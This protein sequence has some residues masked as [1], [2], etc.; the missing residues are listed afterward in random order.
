MRPI[1]HF[2]TRYPE[3]FPFVFIFVHERPHIVG[4][5]CRAECESAGEIGFV[6]V[7]EPSLAVG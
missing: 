1:R 2:I 7:A 3:T 6:A 4:V 5:D